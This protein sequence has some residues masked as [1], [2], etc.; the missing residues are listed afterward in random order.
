MGGTAEVFSSPGN[1]TEVVLRF[2]FRLAREKD[3]KKKIA[4]EKAAGK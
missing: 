4:V 2:K 3:M 1:G